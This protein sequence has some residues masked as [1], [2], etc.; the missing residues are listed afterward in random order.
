VTNQAQASQSY[1]DLVALTSPLVDTTRHDTNTYTK[2]H[3]LEVGHRDQRQRRRHDV[4]I[5]PAPAPRSDALSI[6]SRRHN[7]EPPTD[8]FWPELPTL[9]QSLAV[10]GVKH[11][12]SLCSKHHSSS[13]SSALALPRHRHVGSATPLTPSRPALLPT[14]FSHLPSHSLPFRPRCSLLTT[15]EQD[16]HLLSPCWRRHL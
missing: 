4:T 12:T 5:G 8:P 11:P 13:R 7:V 2:R 15:A 16:P 6:R 9:S 1:H 3:H 14:I 10:D